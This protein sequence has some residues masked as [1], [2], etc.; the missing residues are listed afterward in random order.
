ME[1]S[2]ALTMLGSP[3]P[4][5]KVVLEFGHPTR[6]TEPFQLTTVLSALLLLP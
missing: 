3:L 1:N 4:L 6:L 2:G 5:G